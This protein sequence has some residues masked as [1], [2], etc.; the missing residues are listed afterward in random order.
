MIN[1]NNLDRSL[2]TIDK[3]SYKDIDIYYI[4]YITIKKKKKKNDDYKNIYSVNPLY[5]FIGNV[6]GHIEGKNESKYLVFDSI[7]E[8]REVIEKYTELWDGIKNEI[9][10]INSGKEG[11]YGKDFMKVKFDTVDDLPLNKPLKWH[12]LT[13]I[14]R[15]AFQEE[16]K[17]YPQIYLDECL[18]EL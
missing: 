7:D 3:K 5:L 6:Y 16:E 8:N 2:L 1:L 9:E 17:L 10:R 15:C 18:F 4:R 12:M 11:K 13:V 14:I